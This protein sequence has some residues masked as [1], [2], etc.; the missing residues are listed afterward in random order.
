M[1]DEFFGKTDDKRGNVASES[2]CSPV[3][4]PIVRGD[5]VLLCGFWHFNDLPVGNEK[6]AALFLIKITGILKIEYV[7]DPERFRR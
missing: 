6:P 5:R 4:A 7:T 2:V 1:K 3:V